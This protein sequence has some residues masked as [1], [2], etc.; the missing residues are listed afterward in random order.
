[1]MQKN[2]SKNIIS[3]GS[4]S[5]TIKY[6]CALII[7]AIFGTFLPIKIGNCFSSKIPDLNLLK[8]IRGT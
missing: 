1:M 4:Y 3:S 8:L 7:L 2:A 5:I 6:M